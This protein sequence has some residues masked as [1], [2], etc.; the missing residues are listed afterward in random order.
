MTDITGPIS[1]QTLKVSITP[2]AGSE[3]FIS[4][5]DGWNFDNKVDSKDVTA[6]AVTAAG[7]VTWKSYIATLRDASGTIS[8]KYLALDD[9]GQ[10]A[11]WT[12]FT[13]ANALAEIRFYQDETHYVFCD[14]IATSFPL[15]AKLDGVQGEG[16]TVNV[17][18]QDV[19]GLQLGGYS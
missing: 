16:M 5:V 10:L 11:L 17:Q 8:L 6:A 12:L 2:T 14:C 13:T 19:D 18:I 7:T 3:T 15:G 1:G 4:G 9:P